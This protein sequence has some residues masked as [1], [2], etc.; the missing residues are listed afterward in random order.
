MARRSSHNK[1]KRETSL[2]KINIVKPQIWNFEIIKGADAWKEVVYS[3]RMSGVPSEIEGESVFKMMVNNDYGSV[4]EHVIIKFDL[5]MTKGNAPELLEH[6]IASHTTFSTRYIKANEGI[7]KQTPVYEIIVPWHLLKFDN[8]QPLKKIFLESI[9]KGIGTYEELLNQGMPKESA[10][11]T[12]PFCQ[13]VAVS[14]ITINLRSLLN[15]LSLRLCVRASP[16]FRCLA[17]QLY[18]NLIERLPIMKGLV[19]CRG[20]MRGTCPESDVT[21]VRKGEQHS[22]YPPC[23]FNNP[24]LDIFIP[25]TKE[26]RKGVSVKNFNKDKA[27]EAQAMIFKR[28]ADWE[29]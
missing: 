23:P 27:M 24:N 9:Q 5:K 25:T 29:G 2:M 21:G 22:I 6:R 17:G 20:F 16:E 14:H 8:N 4:L 13:A 3:A 1:R 7:E 26:L 11:Y 15:L 18:F 28:W 19:G 10:R 12:L